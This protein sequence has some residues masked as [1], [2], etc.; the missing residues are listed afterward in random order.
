MKRMRKS[1]PVIGLVALL[2]IAIIGGTFAYFTQTD[3]A[4]NYLAAK[5]YDSTLTEDFEPPPDG[6]TPEVEVVKEVGVTNTGEIPMLVRITYE[7]YW[8]NVLNAGLVLADPVAGIYDGDTEADSLVRKTAGSGWLYGGDGYFYFMTVLAPGGVTG[9][10]ITAIEL[11][12]AAAVTTKTYT[13]KSWNGVLPDPDVQ[14][15]TGPTAEDDKDAFITSLGGQYPYQV[16]T[17]ESTTMPGGTDYRL[18]LTT[19][20]IQAIGEAADTWAATVTV[21]AVDLFLDAI[22]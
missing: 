2:I 10:F 9:K 19:Q 3:T 15:F 21:P 17:N 6:F 4:E 18:K 22:V 8:D 12:D 14:T 5:N 11:K 1:L 20:T 16:I 13:V 7:E